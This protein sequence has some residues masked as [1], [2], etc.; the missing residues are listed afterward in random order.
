[1]RIRP[2]LL[3]AALWS[4]GSAWAGPGGGV[5]A[6]SFLIF[7][8][9]DSGYGEL[10]LLTVTNTLSGPAGTVKLLYVYIDGDDWNEFNR[11]E[12]LTPAD[13]LCVI[14]ANHNP[15][16]A[17]GW[18]WVQ[19][20]DPDTD[21]PIDFDYLMGDLLHVGGN[22]TRS[23][24]TEALTFRG[25]SDEGGAPLGRSLRGHAFADQ[26]GNGAADFDGLEYERWPD[27]L[28]LS[29]FVEQRNGV[30]DWLVLLAPLPGS[31]RVD[32]RLLIYS[33]DERPYSAQLSF[34]CW[35]RLRLLDLNAIT[36]RLNGTAAELPTG[37]VRLEGDSAVNDYTGTR[38]SRAPIL[39]MVVRTGGPSIWSSHLLHGRGERSGLTLPP[40]AR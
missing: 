3:A 4:L 20:L 6:G 1:M 11:T 14:A 28:A 29:S 32:V 8:Y 34:R 12:T 33:N 35:R 23:F 22:F 15:A 24:S 37:W 31:F 25:L 17:R 30:E 19:A 10:S 7:P 2:W 18:L 5:P 36:A 16:F 13:T 40:T 27:V 38:L 21:R 39:G 9:F 26:N